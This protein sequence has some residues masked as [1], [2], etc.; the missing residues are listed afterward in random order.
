[1]II[2]KKILILIFLSFAST[3]A[4]SQIICEKYDEENLICSSQELNQLSTN[5][6]KFYNE[7]KII[8]SEFS[9]NLK[10]KLNE[11]L[12]QCAEDIVC[13]TGSISSSISVLK[14]NLEISQK[15]KNNKSIND[16]VASVGVKNITETNQVSINS[17]INTITAEQAHNSRDI[18]SLIKDP[19]VYGF[20]I[21]LLLFV[22]LYFAKNNPD[23]A[24]FVTNILYWSIGF[25]ILLTWIFLKLILK[26]S[27]YS[28]N[29]PS[30]SAGSLKRE[31]HVKKNDH[32]ERETIDI[33]YQTSSGAWARMHS[34]EYLGNDQEISHAMKNGLNTAMLK[35]SGSTGKVRAKG[36]RTKTIYDIS[37]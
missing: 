28:Q 10:S 13:M 14:N 21:Y 33:E 34:F 19:Y 29:E 23:A 37:G 16:A 24:I 12:L 31:N 27:N 7:Y 17:E 22:F 5:F 26:K 20:I 8:D 3:F 18:I 25:P 35:G 9:E 32:P 30:V 4:L 1:M 11:Q 15:E 2:Y 6:L 36:R